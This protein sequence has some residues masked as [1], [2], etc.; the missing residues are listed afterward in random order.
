M[1]AL[2]IVFQILIA[3]VVVAL[4]AS[5]KMSDL[6][7][8]I[9]IVLFSVKTCLRAIQYMLQS[10]SYLSFAIKWYSLRHAPGALNG[11][12]AEWSLFMDCLQDFLGYTGSKLLNFKASRAEAS[13]EVSSF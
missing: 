11:R 12:R 5:L 1:E 9:Y 8:N 7:H 6:W 2:L 10:D 3:I 4:G 13:A